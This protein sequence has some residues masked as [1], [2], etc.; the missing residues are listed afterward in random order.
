MP[1]SP[2]VEQFRLLVEIAAVVDRIDAGLDRDAQAAAAERMADHPAV[3]RVRLL[4][5]CLHLVEVEGAVMRPVPR[6]RAGAAG[7]GAFDHIGPGAHDPPHHRPDIGEAVDDA[8]GQQ[9]VVR[10][11]ARETRRADPVADA[12]DRRDDDERH[13]E[14]RPGD[15][16]F[17]DRPLEP[18]VEAGGVADRRIAGGERLLQHLG[19]AQ[20]ARRLRLVD[21]PA[22]RQIVAV[23]RQMV[24]GVD[25][26][27]QHRHAGRCR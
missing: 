24:M 22:P 13:D 2:S 18:G 14:P 20:G 6:A 15:Q 10:H 12:A 3:E 11:A 21:A 1:R 7:R 17:V 8:V 25:Q 9:R 4:D 16:P 27:R 19:G 5:Q 26:P 23:H